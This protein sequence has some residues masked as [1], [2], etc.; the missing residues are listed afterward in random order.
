MEYVHRI[1]SRYHR[2]CRCPLFH[3]VSESSARNRVSS[4]IRCDVSLITDKKVITCLP[5]GRQ[6]Y[7]PRVSINLIVYNGE[8]YLPFALSSIA[9]QTFRDFSVLIIDNHSHDESI[10]FIEQFLEDPS[11]KEL[12]SVTTLI[13]NRKND[14]FAPAHNHAIHWSRS[15]YVF[16]MNQDVIL[17]DRY[18][19]ELTNFL[20]ARKDAAAASGMIFRWDLTTNCKTDS[21]DTLGLVLTNS[22]KVVEWRD[23]EDIKEPR[24]VFGVSGALPMYRRSALEVVKTPMFQESSKLYGENRQATVY[25]YFDTDFFIYKEDV[26]LAYRLRLLGWSAYLVPGAIAWHDRTAAAKMGTIPNRRKKSSFV[27]FYSYRNHLYFLIKNL[28][29]PI[30]IRHAHRIIPYELAKFFYV[31][32]FEPRTLR[33]L[34]D[35]AKNLRKMLKKRLFIKKQSGKDGWKNIEK[36]L[37]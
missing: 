32:F 21:I 35:F 1:N 13:K 19:E 4:S 14:G 26:D 9:N 10:A 2:A 8:K 18:L 36:W 12:S 6:S 33:A 37:R 30:F 3:A 7:M 34:P 20:D 24:E 22:H 28:Q 27:N 17:G 16:M 23:Y 31:L 25:E 5:S 15:D 11:H 29:F